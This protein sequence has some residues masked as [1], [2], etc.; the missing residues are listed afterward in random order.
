MNVE[1]KEAPRIVIPYTPR[2]HFRALHASVARWIFIVAHRRAGKTVALCN[3]TIRKALENKRTFPPPRYGYVGPSFAQT[4][5]LVWGY[6]KHYTSVLPNMK[7]SEGELQ[8]VLP[9][10]A[11]INLYGGAAAYERMR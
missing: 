10:G 6:Y 7:I 9:N 1:V 2:E 4:K 8:V 11:M 3:Q 5:D